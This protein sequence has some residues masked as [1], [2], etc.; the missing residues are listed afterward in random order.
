ML[1]ELQYEKQQL[2]ENLQRKKS[3]QEIFQFEYKN[4]LT[5]VKKRKK[6]KKKFNNF[7]SFLFYE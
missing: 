5:K 7:I 1:Q 6:E 2:K 4:N 3:L